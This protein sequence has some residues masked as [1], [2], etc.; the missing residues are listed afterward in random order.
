MEEKENTLSMKY[1]LSR[2][3]ESTESGMDIYIYL[4]CNL[5]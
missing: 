3:R 1:A 2:K 5:L 4:C